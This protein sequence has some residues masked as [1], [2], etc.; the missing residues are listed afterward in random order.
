M[1][2]DCQKTWLPENLQPLSIQEEN[3][4]FLQDKIA[5]SR[6][7]ILFEESSHKFEDKKSQLCYASSKLGAR[8]VFAGSFGRKV[9]Q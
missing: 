5:A 1:I 4:R 8:Y 3:R 2:T 9:E 7:S 6:Y